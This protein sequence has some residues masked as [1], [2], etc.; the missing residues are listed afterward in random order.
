MTGTGVDHE[1]L[2]AVPASVERHLVG[3]T[4]AHV[5]E[6]HV[7]RDATQRCSLVQQTGRRAD[8]VV[9]GVLNP[10]R[11]VASGRVGTSQPQQRQSSRA[12]QRV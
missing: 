9:L 5:K 4:G 2:E 6:Q 1:H 7:R 12:F 11:N 10:L 8:I 3:L